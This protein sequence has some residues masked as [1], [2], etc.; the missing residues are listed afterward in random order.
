MLKEFYLGLYRYLRLRKNTW[1]HRLV[2]NVGAYVDPISMRFFIPDP[3]SALELK[4]YW[5]TKS[6]ISP[7][8][9]MILSGSYEPYTVC[10]QR[11]LP[12]NGVFVDIG[13]NVGWFSLIAAQRVGPRG[14][15]YAFEPHPDVYPLLVKNIKVNGF[16]NV[17]IPIRKA[18]SSAN[19][20]ATFYSAKASV[21]AGLFSQTLY[22]KRMYRRPIYGKQRS[23][24]VET[25]TLDDFF[26]SMGWP[27]LN[28]VKISS[29]GSEKATLEK[30]GEVCKRNSE[31]KMLVDFRPRTLNI[32]GVLPKDFFYEFQSLGFRSFTAVRYGRRLRIP[33]DIEWLV[34]NAGQFSTRI[35]CEK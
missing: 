22:G 16:E 7:V 5:R 11:L 9:R 14:K 25:V 18:V 30:M 20:N 19:G 4:V 12:E 13:A 17:I 26:G 24:E 8:A 29:E 1:F 6:E 21:Y 27:L 15:V 28:F 31:L 35:L 32:I 34:E 23:W 10:V 2:R 3:I 33:D